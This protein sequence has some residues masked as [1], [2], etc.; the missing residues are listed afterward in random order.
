MLDPTVHDVF[1]AAHA[2]RGLVRETSLEPAPALDAIAGGN[3]FLKLENL[4]YTG[5]FK[6]RGALN[7]VLSLSAAER[8]RG[9]LAASSGNH[10]QG[11]ALAARHVG[12]QATVV[13]PRGTALNKLESCRR[14]GAEVIEAG[15]DYDEAEVAAREMAAKRGATL[16]HAFADPRVI[17]GQGTVA[18]E[19]LACEPDL[20]LFLVPAGGGGLIGGMA[21]AIKAVNPRAQVIG[22]QSFASPVWYHCFRAGRLVDVPIR[23][24]IAEGLHGGIS[25]PP[26]TL[27]S[28][29]VDDFVLV[30]EEEIARAIP[31]LV[32]NH[33]QLAEPSGAAA[34]AAVLYGR[35]ATAG[36]RVGIVISGGNVDVA[37]L[38]GYLRSG[39][40]LG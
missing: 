30:E 27:V 26:F 39:G 18:L 17:A 14:L 28:R 25:D 15:R 34:L 29:V 10:A 21:V 6:L 33:R 13:V 19:M 35:V 5:S 2:I 31:W 12:C 4:Q 7:C 11:V 23:E 22:V 36:R 1:R 20:D 37:R 9:L 16:V 38:T 32:Q 8:A 40:A 24:S 3:A